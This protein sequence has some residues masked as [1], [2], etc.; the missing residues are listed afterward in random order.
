MLARAITF[1][2]DVERTRDLVYCESTSCDRGIHILVQDYTTAHQQ[3]LLSVYR[4]IVSRYLS[5][6]HILSSTAFIDDIAKRIET[7]GGEARMSVGDLRIAG[8]FVVLVAPDGAHLLT[9]R[10]DLIHVHMDGE[11][12]RLSDALGAERLYLEEDEFQHELFPERLRSAFHVYRVDPA[13]VLGADLLLGCGEE[14]RSTVVEILTDPAAIDPSNPRVTVVSR[15]VT[16]KL[17]GLRF[18]EET[19]ALSRAP[20]R[21]ALA[22][23]LRG[24]SAVALA[25]AIT[26]AAVIAGTYLASRLLSEKPTAG[27]VDLPEVVESASQGEHAEAEDPKLAE[28]WSET[29]SQPV[30]SSPVLIGERVVFGCRDGSV[31][32]L[33]RESG[34]R[35]WAFASGSGVGASP[36]VSGG[37]VFGADYSGN[38]FAINADTGSRIWEHKL[39]QRVVST[40]AVSG[41]RIVVGCYDGV[42]YCLS[43]VDGNPLWKRKTGGR[44]RGSVGVADGCFFVP[45]YDGYLYALGEEDGSVRWRYHVGR[46]VSSTP[47]T[48]KGAVIIGGEDG[49]IHC[50]NAITGS[51]KWK[52]KTGGAV[53]SAALVAGARVYAGSNDG[54]VHCM[55]LA[56]GA[57]LWQVETGDVVLGRPSLQSGH[58][59]A[60]SYDGFV[61]C[62]DAVSGELID[63]WDTGAAVFSSPTADE[64]A[65]YVGNNEG[66]FLCL[67]YYNRRRAS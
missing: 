24:R 38:V 17:L 54:R 7:L 31:Y 14:D 19:V 33:D 35:A 11:L 66:R 62:V 52:Y 49:V 42:A 59:F 4:E 16:R 45:S 67:A 10:D 56:D 34:K 29:F 18:S 9:T 41:E 61:Y 58:V 43:T 23:R 21:P 15:F 39:P 53:K 26:V 8:I 37:V 20:R 64:T 36:V 48:G 3:F 1:Q 2:P 28:E 57:P 60:G 5:T 6:R 44:I 25:G 65:V 27:T 55:G 40:P 13:R 47:A 30:T 50:I 22:V 12:V 51:N 46:Q 63:R 32:A